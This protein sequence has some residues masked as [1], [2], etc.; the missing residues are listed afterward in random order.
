MKTLILFIAVGLAIGAQLLAQS[1]TL[2]SKERLTLSIESEPIAKVLNLIAV[3][4]HL[5]LVLSDNVK[6]DV[7]VRLDNVDLRT[8]LDAILT[9][10]GY[11][12]FL[13]DNVIVVKDKKDASQDDLSSQVITLKFADPITVKKALEARRSEKGQI[14][15]LDRAQE[16]RASDER[17]SA[18][19]ILISD[20]PSVV[21]EMTRLVADMDVPE[22]VVQIEAR[23]LETTLDRKTNLGFE[24]PTAV[25]TKITGVDDGTGS[26]STGTTTTTTNNNLGALDVQSGRWTWGRLSVGQLNA[27]LNLLQQS[28]NSKLISDPKITTLE[29][30]QAEITSATVIPVQ[31]INRFT[32][33]AQTQDIVTFQDIDVAISL[34]VTP[35]LTGD[36]KITLEVEPTVQDIIGY[37]GTNGN[38]KPITTSRSVKTHIT[39]ADGESVA[40]GGMLKEN[41]ITKTQKFPLLGEIPLIGRL[42][43]TSTSKEKSTTDLII[44]ITPHVLP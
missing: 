33:A 19:R 39:V 9:A 26:T 20:L 23:I 27:V 14:I 6:G 13:R 25:S 16:G 21:A 41:D 10:N 34:K 12:Y 28:G 35:R 36:G 32:E 4:N 29:N 8:A 38:L 11:A 5:N 40:L 31:T 18:N 7:S 3:Q 30:H 24:W 42:L 44:L 22:R 37:S 15:I 1:S 43:F 2:D 17:Y